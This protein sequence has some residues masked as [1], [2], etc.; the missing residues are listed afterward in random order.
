MDFVFQIGS[1]FGLLQPF[2]IL[3][4][5]SWCR[6]IRCRTKVIDHKC[7]VAVEL[8]RLLQHA[9]ALALQIIS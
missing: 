1:F 4:L 6:L 8:G 3:V 7:D 5:L 9:L 2:R